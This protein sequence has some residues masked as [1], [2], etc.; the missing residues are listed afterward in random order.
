MLVTWSSAASG[1]DT[2]SRPSSPAACQ[3]GRSRYI[4]RP[5]KKIPT[6]TM[7]PIALPTSA[8]IR[9]LLATCSLGKRELGRHRYTTPKIGKNKLAGTA[10]AQARRGWRTDLEEEVVAA[11]R[12]QDAT[13]RLAL[14]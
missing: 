12:L 4:D 9:L 5:I 13:E 11:E 14:E 6:S 2:T 8:T 10:K 1:P 7:Q 3:R